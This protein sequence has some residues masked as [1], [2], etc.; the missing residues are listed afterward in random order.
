MF[1]PPKILIM[2]NLLIKDQTVNTSRNCQLLYKLA[3]DFKY[4]RRYNR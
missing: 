4:G 1:Y 3:I 2:Y